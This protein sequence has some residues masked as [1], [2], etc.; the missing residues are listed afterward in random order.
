MSLITRTITPRP[1]VDDKDRPD[2]IQPSGTWK[3]DSLLA[4]PHWLHFK[5]RPSNSPVVFLSDCGAISILSCHPVYVNSLQS[6]QLNLQGFQMCSRSL[7]C[8]CYGLSHN[9]QHACQLER[10]VRASPQRARQSAFCSVVPQQQLPVHL[11]VGMTL[12]QA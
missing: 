8:A 9:L 11:L 12:C 1:G 5:Q 10:R 3:Q 4:Q 7:D 6:A 2:Q